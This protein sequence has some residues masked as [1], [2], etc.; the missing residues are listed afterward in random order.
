MAL[1]DELVKNTTRAIIERD[2]EIYNRL[3]ENIKYFSSC[4]RTSYTIGEPNNSPRVNNFY[5]TEWKDEYKSVLEE[6]KLKVEY[7]KTLFG[8]KKIII[9]WG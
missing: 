8:N 6:E 5:D 1:K 4:G 9:S 2:K 3:I 7:K